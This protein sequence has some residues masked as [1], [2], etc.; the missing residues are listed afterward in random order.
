MTSKDQ[1]TTPQ[2]IT[3]HQMWSRNITMLQVL[4]P[5]ATHGIG[6]FNSHQNNH[7]KQVQE[8]ILKQSTRNK[9]NLKHKDPK[10]TTLLTSNPNTH[11]QIHWPE[12]ITSELMK[13]CPLPSSSSVIAVFFSSVVFFFCR[14]LLLFRFFFSQSS[15]QH[16]LRKMTRSLS[17][18][19]ASASVAAF[20][21]V[22][23]VVRCCCFNM[24]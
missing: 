22:V 16:A 24:F 3:K 5:T 7:Q 13:P 6:C 2:N 12:G 9:N 1:M 18:V 10:Q 21:V 17:F 11:T 8:N 23:V 20:V 15:F 14:L 4:K 19:F